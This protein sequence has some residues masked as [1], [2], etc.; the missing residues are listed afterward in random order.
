MADPKEQAAI[1]RAMRGIVSP[2]IV[3]LGAHTG[4]DEVWLRE[5]C[6]DAYGGIAGVH[7]VMVEPD[8]RNCQFILDRQ[9]TSRIRRLIIGA[10][11]DQ[12]GEA[13]FHMSDNERTGDHGSGSILEP[14]GHKTGMPWIKFDRA[15]WVRTYTLDS[16]FDREWLS[17]IDL[18]WTD[19]Q[20]SERAML[21][22]GKEALRHTRFLFMEVENVEL[23]AGQA[24]KPELI[25]LAAGHGFEVVEEFQYNVLLMNGRFRERGP[26]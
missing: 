8:P 25:E 7:Y 4:E 19:V 22:G 15:T 3:E 21:A 18:L 14:T 2:C 26:R 13:L 20:G 1:R 17:K 12:D 6:I 23:Y 5:S 16:L 10:V 24:L 9:Q 11:A